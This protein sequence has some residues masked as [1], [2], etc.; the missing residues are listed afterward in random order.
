MSV[1]IVLS[2]SVYKIFDLRYFRIESVKD[3]I[4]YWYKFN[5][6]KT[7][8]LLFPLIFKKKTTN[9]YIYNDTKFTLGF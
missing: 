1:C 6:I 5:W 3:V 4:D 9:M 2:I 8:K 7:I